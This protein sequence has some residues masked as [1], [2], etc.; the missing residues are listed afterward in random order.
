MHI[1]NAKLNA[2]NI[3]IFYV[4]SY[5][6][7]IS[8]PFTRITLNVIAF[9]SSL[10]HKLLQSAIYNAAFSNY[11]RYTSSRH[12][13]AFKCLQLF[14]KNSSHSGTYFN[15]DNHSSYQ[16]SYFIAAVK[17]FDSFYAISMNYWYRISSSDLLRSIFITALLF[18]LIH[19]HSPFIHVDQYNEAIFFTLLFIWGWLRFIDLSKSFISY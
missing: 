11:V 19:R 18:N 10:H 3:H 1:L 14:C 4:I 8:V 12:N 9:N 7:I 15:Y 6:Y 5:I 2:Y 13:V 17:Y 16:H